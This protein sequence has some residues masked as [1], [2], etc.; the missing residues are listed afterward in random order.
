M[1]RVLTSLKNRAAVWAKQRTYGKR[2]EPYQVLGEQLHF[3][4]GRRPVRLK[5][6]HS[7]DR[8]AQEEAMALAVVLSCLREGD[9]SLDVGAHAGVYSALM[10]SRCGQSGRVIAFEPDPTAAT[11]FNE[12]FALNPHLMKPQLEN[13]ACSDQTGTAQFFV[14]HGDSRSSLAHGRP[15]FAEMIAVPTITLDEFSEREAV[16]PRLV[17]IDVEGAEVSVLRGAQRLLEGDAVVICELHPFAW[18]RFGTSLDELIT[19]AERANRTIRY[20]SETT[21]I[22]GEPVYGLAL[23]ER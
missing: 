2:G 8:L 21:P 14:S 13:L 4:I 6:V 10:A 7:H 16:K 18:A 5:H 12:T 17:K 23:I 3:P 1:K 20:L 15:D 9:V 22:R 19:L 11:M